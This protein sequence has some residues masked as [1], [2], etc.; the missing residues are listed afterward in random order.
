[1]KGLILPP[2][3][4]VGFSFADLRCDGQDAASW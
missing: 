3:Q 4:D 1:V 2:S